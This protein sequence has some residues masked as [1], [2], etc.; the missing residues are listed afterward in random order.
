MWR[1]DGW[2]AREVAMSF[3]FF[4]LFILGCS[5]SSLRFLGLSLVAASG[6]YSLGA[7][8]WLLIKAASLFVKHRL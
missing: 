7:V 3:F 5:E 1:K 4:N 8:P 6:G 2:T